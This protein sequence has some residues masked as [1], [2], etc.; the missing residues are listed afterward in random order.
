MADIAKVNT[1]AA[2]NIAS[3][4]GV[5]KAN[6]GKI[7]N[8]NVP[9]GGA[10]LWCVVAEDGGIATAAHSDLNDWTGYDATGLGTQDHITLAHGKDGSG[11][12]LWVA[13]TQ[14]GNREI[15]YS[16][17]PT[18]G[19]DWADVSIAG[20]VFGVAWGNDVWIAVGQ[21]GEVHRSTNGTTWTQLDISGATG[22]SDSVTIWD[23]VTDGAGKWM[24]CQG[25]NIFHS[26]DDGATW[27]LLIH[28]A[29]TG[30]LDIDG[31]SSGGAFTSTSMAYTDSRWCVFLW[32]AGGDN[33]TLVCHAPAA[34]TSASSWAICTVSG[35]A[36]TG[37]ALIGKPAR[38]MA[39]GDG[40]VIIV[41]ANR[42]S[43]STDGGQDWT[44]YGGTFPGTGL[45]PRTD[46]RDVATDG[47]GNWVAVHDSGRVSLSTDDGLTW[48]EQTGGQLTFP[49]STLNIEAVAS[50]VFLPV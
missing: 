33:R 19:A 38:R 50:D 23:V 42:I 7:G 43:R 2:A 13:G 34:D 20:D 17:D 26:T 46:A 30:G 3:I 28:L 35:S 47:D 8:T 18:D 40:T 41:Q 16:S 21:A 36:P 39:A 48:V 49:S 32:A 25:A 44:L 5:A 29:D 37:Q 15:R 6:I 11:D 1:V 10:T 9:A 31:S 14:D 45:L 24:C 12:P 22:Y 4:G 27:A